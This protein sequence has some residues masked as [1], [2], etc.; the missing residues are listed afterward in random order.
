M[1]ARKFL[2]LFL[3]V[4]SACTTAPKQLAPEVA[5]TKISFGS[6]AHPKFPQPIW[7]AMQGL[8][9]QV[10]LAMGDN[11]YG[12]S[13]Q[14]K[15]L[16]Q[17]YLKQAQIPEYKH[18]HDEVPFLGTWDDHD[19]GQN[20]GGADNPDKKMAREEFLKYL[21]YAKPLVPQNGEGIYHS[22][23][24]GPEG[25][26][27]NFIFLDTRWFRSPLVINPKP[28]SKLDRFLPSPDKTATVLGETQW[29]WLSEELKRPA[30]LIVVISSIQLIPNDHKFEKWGNFPLE[31]KRML[32][33][34]SLAPHPLIVLSGDRH[35]AEI[36][37]EIVNKKEILEITASSINRAKDI[38]EEKNIAR[39]GPRFTPENFGWL[40][41]DW[42]ARKYAASIR[43]VEGKVITS[44][45]RNF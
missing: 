21:P 39:I 4:L 13:P 43:D 35:F 12:S 15:P 30:D 26:R 18:F 3:M 29:A 1:N 10:Y 20:D 42:S 27:I 38:P 41:I 37:H 8:H 45:V 25:Q 44:Q 16:D 6:C 17:A 24:M 31:R 9:P 14:D 34:L 5:L 22:V 11:V 23:Q 7:S 28:K 40:Q 33:L 36:S 2:F 32:E 19:Y